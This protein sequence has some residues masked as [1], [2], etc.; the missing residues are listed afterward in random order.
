MTAT[1]MTT[2]AASERLPGRGRR[3]R[4][5]GAGRMILRRLALFP[6]VT[7]VVSA[8]L[9]AAAAASPFDPLAAYLGNRYLTASEESKAA[10]TATLG[11]DAPWYTAYWWWISDLINGDLG[12]SR[13]FHQPVADVLAERLPWTFLLVTTSLVVAIP[14]AL[15]LGTWAGMRPGSIIDRVIT[16][17]ALAVQAMPPFVLALATIA[18]F[19]LALGWLPPAGITD[20]GAAPSP[21]QVARHIV[22]PASVLAISQMPWLLL[23]ARESITA[24]LSSSFVAGARARG[25][26][27][28]RILTGHVLPSSLAPVLTILGARLPELI[29]GAVLVEEVFSWPGIA[30]ALVTSAQHLD[31][32]LL[33]MLTIATTLAVLLGSLLADLA[34]LVAD[35]RVRADG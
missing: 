9:F 7:I 15:L 13:A 1:A 19:A 18:V 21:D 4:E 26:S 31:L 6:I 22:L 28:R 12:Y 25:I 3:L 16:M 23:A 20:A 27:E 29:V 14:V 30:A 11:L 8:A 5:R 35:P 17:I 34:Y 2:T 24:S 33:A 10:I 32:P